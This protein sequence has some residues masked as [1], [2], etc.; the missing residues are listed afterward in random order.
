MDNFSDISLAQFT[1][2]NSKSPAESLFKRLIGAITETAAIGLLSCHITV[3][4]SETSGSKSSKSYSI[5]NSF[6][7]NLLAFIKAL[8]GDVFSASNSFATLE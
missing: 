4:I 3:D 6:S 2:S 8:P 7:F 1:S 5:G